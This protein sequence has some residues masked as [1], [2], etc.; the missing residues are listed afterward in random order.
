M[1]G[2]VGRIERV[3]PRE[4]LVEEPELTAKGYRL[5]D[6][7]HGGVKHHSKHA[8]YVKTLDEAADLIE[9]GFSLWMVAKGKRASL[10]SP[11]SLRIVRGTPG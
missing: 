9:R 10:I 11:Q 7:A 5:G 6:P 1:G 2:L 4:D 3:S 8:V